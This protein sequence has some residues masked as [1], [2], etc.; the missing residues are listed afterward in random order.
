MV[1]E[2][3]TLDQHLGIPENAGRDYH[4]IDLTNLRHHIASDFYRRNTNVEL[5]HQLCF[6]CDG[7][8]NMFFSMWK[9]CD[10]CKGYGHLA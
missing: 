2:T 1:L 4:L 6:D 9:K 10:T 3:L 8:G 5:G 7:T